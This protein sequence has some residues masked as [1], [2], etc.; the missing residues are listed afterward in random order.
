MGEMLVGVMVDARALRWVASM[1]ARMGLT[2]AACWGVLMA[3]LWASSRVAPKAEKSVHLME[4]Y[5]VAS[6]DDWW[7]VEKVVVM[8]IHSADMMG[9][10]LDP[11]TAGSKAN[12]SV[13][14]KVVLRE[15]SM[16][17]LKVAR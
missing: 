1:V 14:T 9:V 5:L 7:A 15:L 6:T 2:T 10:D 8:A 11:Q 16:A 3:E 12:K 4:F 17:V 13:E